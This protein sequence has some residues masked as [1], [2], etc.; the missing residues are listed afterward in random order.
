M[1]TADNRNLIKVVVA[2]DVSTE[3]V[4]SIARTFAKDHNIVEY[5]VESR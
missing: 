4:S 2:G 5:S 3:R 1:N